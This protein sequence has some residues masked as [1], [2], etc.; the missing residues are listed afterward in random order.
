M[1]NKSLFLAIMASLS[2]V[3]YSNAT[4]YDVDVKVVEP[5]C[6]S[7]G[8]TEHTRENFFGLMKKK[9][10]LIINLNLIIMSNLR[11]L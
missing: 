9:C 5:T 3:S 8:Y 2:C 1:K 11:K 4:P 7:E 10:F 6:I